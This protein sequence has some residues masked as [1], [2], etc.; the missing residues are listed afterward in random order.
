MVNFCCDFCGAKIELDCN[1]LK[2]V[3]LEEDTNYYIV[4]S[5]CNEKLRNL[6]ENSYAIITIN[7]E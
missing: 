5:K 1:E 3:K 6:T 2:E 4:C 7:V